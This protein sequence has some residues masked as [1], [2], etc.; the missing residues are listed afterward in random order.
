MTI[1]ITQSTRERLRENAISPIVVLEIDGVPRRLGSDVI[2]QIIRIGD[3]NL[4]ID[5]TWFIGG[6]RPLENQ[7]DLVSLGATSTRIRQQLNQDR[8]GS[9]SISTFEI[10]LIDEGRQVSRL[11]S[12]GKEIEEILFRKCKVWIGFGNTAFPD[13]YIEVFQGVIDE[14]QSG[15]GLVKLA[16]VHPDQKKRQ[17]LFPIAQTELTQEM[18]YLSVR[19]QDLLYQARVGFGTDVRIRYLDQGSQDDTF[20]ETVTVSGMDITVNIATAG[21]GITS[22]SDIRAPLRTQEKRQTWWQSL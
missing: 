13:D 21:D 19:I 4:F 22:A 15:A 5:G 6:L 2:L 14:V 17:Q 11:I 3:E 1:E 16:I 12:P 7:E 9:G 10:G 20:E 8:G 18:N